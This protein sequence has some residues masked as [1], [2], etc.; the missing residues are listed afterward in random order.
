MLK[1]ETKFTSYILC[2]P[3]PCLIPKNTRT[4]I[5]LNNLMHK[6]IRSCNRK[7]IS[8]HT[9]YYAPPAI[10]TSVTPS[11]PLNTILNFL[12]HD[13]FL[14]PSPAMPLTWIMSLRVLLIRSKSGSSR[15]GL[16]ISS[17]TGGAC[18]YRFFPRYVTLT[19][20]R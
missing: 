16:V 7:I 19:L 15:F 9:K 2:L 11:I 17:S 3:L 12:K 18:M 8:T 6:S 13:C 4:S 5:R 10:S 20:V 14:S 1:Y